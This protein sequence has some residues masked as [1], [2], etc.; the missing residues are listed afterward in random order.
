MTY[1]EYGNAM[2]FGSWFTFA[3]ALAAL[4]FSLL[5]YWMIRK[6]LRHVLQFKP[7]SQEHIL[8]IHKEVT[9]KDG[10]DGK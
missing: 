2:L 10:S 3:L 5:C 9:D 7:D 4:V 8:E 1:I 6:I